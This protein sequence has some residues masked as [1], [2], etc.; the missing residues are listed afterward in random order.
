MKTATHESARWERHNDIWQTPTG[1]Q[2]T[3]T[4][5]D[6]LNEIFMLRWELE[7]LATRI[8]SVIA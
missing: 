7:T 1:R 4:E 5:Q 2:A 8:A 3:D 6:L